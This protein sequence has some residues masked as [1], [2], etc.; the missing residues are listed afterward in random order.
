MLK[1]KVV[2]SKNKYI[3]GVLPGNKR[4][5]SETVVTLSSVKEIVKCMK[6]G[7][8]YFIREDGTE[9][10][11]SCADDVAK[12]IQYRK[13][14]K[15]MADQPSLINSRKQPVT[16]EIAQLPKEEVAVEVPEQPATETERQQEVRGGRREDRHHHN[17]RK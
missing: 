6:S 4:I 16:Q 1:C 2:P 11:C 13:E 14:M 12:E 3:S 8:V 7:A 10:L 17:N 5:E 15:E 9:V